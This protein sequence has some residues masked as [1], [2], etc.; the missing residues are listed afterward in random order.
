MKFIME[1]IDERKKYFATI[2]MATL[3]GGAAI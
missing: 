3:F 1:L 2:L